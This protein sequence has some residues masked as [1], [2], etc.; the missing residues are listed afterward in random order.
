MA[1]AEHHPS[2]LNKANRGMLKMSHQQLHDFADTKETHLPKRIEHVHE[3]LHTNK[4]APDKGK[5]AQG[6]DHHGPVAGSLAKHEHE[7][8]IHHYADGRSKH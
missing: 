5:T 2:E 6:E 8:V 4:M 3:H 1:I 7:G